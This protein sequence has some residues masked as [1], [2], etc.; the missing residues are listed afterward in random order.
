MCDTTKARSDGVCRH[1]PGIVPG[2][3]QCAVKMQA[4]CMA[5]PCGCFARVP[6]NLPNFTSCTEAPAQTTLCSAQRGG[7]SWEPLPH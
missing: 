3:Q 1:H 2:H 5:R 6:H 4:E 7:E